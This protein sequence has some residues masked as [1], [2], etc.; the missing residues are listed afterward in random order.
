MIDKRE[1]KISCC[2][3]CRSKPGT[4]KKNGAVGRWPAPDVPASGSML[5]IDHVCVGCVCGVTAFAAI[6]AFAAAFAFAAA[7]GT[8]LSMALLNVTG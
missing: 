1:I 8:C 2:C 3:R 4:E 6:A 7:L 5:S